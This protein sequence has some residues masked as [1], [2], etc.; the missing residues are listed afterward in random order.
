MSFSNYDEIIDYIQ[1]STD[2]SLK[3]LL[4]NNKNIDEW[5]LDYSSALNTLIFQF[6]LLYLKW[7]SLPRQELKRY[8]FSH[9]KKVFSLFSNIFTKQKFSLDALIF[10]LNE[11]HKDVVAEKDSSLFFEFFDSNQVC[12][13]SRYYDSIYDWMNYGT[14][15]NDILFDIFDSLFSYLPSLKNAQIINTENSLIIRHLSKDYMVTD[16]YYFDNRQI[17]YYLSFIQESCNETIFNYFCL[18]NYSVKIQLYKKS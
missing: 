6:S 7:K 3:Q 4:F 9:S 2:D 10:A 14:I 15:N 12:R 17:P 11:A 13:Y 18:T 5:D 1:S 16:L 8:S